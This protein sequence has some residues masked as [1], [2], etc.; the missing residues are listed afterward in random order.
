MIIIWKIL[1]KI[2]IEARFKLKTLHFFFYSDI[3][4]ISI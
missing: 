4:V 3:L 2:K 1:F